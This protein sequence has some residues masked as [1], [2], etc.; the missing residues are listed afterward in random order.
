[1]PTDWILG[2]AALAALGIG[3]WIAYRRRR[4]ARKRPSNPGDIY[5][6]W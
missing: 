5:P 3:A 4:A 1:M 6:V 2:L